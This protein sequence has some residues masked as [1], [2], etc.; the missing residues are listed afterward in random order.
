V[1]PQEI[2]EEWKEMNWEL[3]SRNEK[4]VTLKINYMFSWLLSEI[5]KSLYKILQFYYYFRASGKVWEK[6]EKKC[7]FV[8]EKCHFCQKVW[9]SAILVQKCEIT[10]FGQIVLNNAILLK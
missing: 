5:I 7:D 8:S 10:D 2:V 9:K 1:K 4:K 3:W 6:L